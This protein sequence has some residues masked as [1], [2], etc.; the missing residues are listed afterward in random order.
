MML[1]RLILRHI[2]V[3][4][5]V[6][7]TV[8]PGYS[9][10]TVI[11]EL[12]SYPLLGQNATLTDLQISIAHNESRLARAAELVGMSAA[13]YRAFRVATQTQRPQWGRVPQRLN[14]M[15]W[16]SAGQ[17]RVIHDVEI[18]RATYGFEYDET[19]PAER[20]RIFLPV[21][22]GNLSILRERVRRA[23]AIKPPVAVSA[24]TPYKAAPLAIAT[25]APALAAAAPQ[26]TQTSPPT[27]YLGSQRRGGVFPFLAGLLGFLTVGGGGHGGGGHGGGGGGGGGCGCTKN[28]Q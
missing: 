14:A 7:V 24:I 16:Y 1:T 8:S 2:L 12:G 15:A 9:A 5:I 6:A 23:A 11:A 27:I 10:P 17:V 22:C 21:A 18:P 26:P 25:A 13:E 3:A 4:L 19:G 20:L 28:P